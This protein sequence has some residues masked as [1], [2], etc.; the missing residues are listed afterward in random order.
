M[1]SENGIWPDLLKIML[2]RGLEGESQIQ[3]QIKWG[4]DTKA[5]TPAAQAVVLQNLIR[6]PKKLR[7]SLT[8][9]NFLQLLS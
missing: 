3:E 7:K 2:L 8:N 4:P 6:S 1:N 5:L 9:L